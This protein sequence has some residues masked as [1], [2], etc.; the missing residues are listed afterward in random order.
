MVKITQ[1]GEIL[2][3]G[4]VVIKPGMSEE[5]FTKS[6]YGSKAELFL[7]NEGYSD[8]QLT[9]E[10]PDDLGVAMILIFKE[11]TIES[12][13]FN[14]LWEGSPRSW[15]EWSLETEMEIKRKNDLFLKENLGEPPYQY[16]WGRVV[17]VFDK[18]DQASDII[19]TYE[20]PQS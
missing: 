16:S 14:P 10:H 9:V 18:R 1:N 19:V 7:T 6:L 8:Y 20:H 2:I 17:S 15:S 13:E 5:E 11:D 12:V 3:D 4:V